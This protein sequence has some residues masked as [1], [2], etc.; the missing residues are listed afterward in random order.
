MPDKIDTPETSCASASTGESPGPGL[1]SRRSRFFAMVGCAALVVLAFP[2]C[3]V[4]WLV[5]V[6]LVPL[7]FAAQGIGGKR[8]F[9]T[10]WITGMMIEGVGFFWISHA[11]LHFSGLPL[12]VAYVLFLGWAAL[13]ALT[14]AVFGWALGRCR[15][16]GAV[17][18]TLPLWVAVEFY[19]PRLFDWHFG[20]ALYQREWLRQAADVFGASGLSYWILLVNALVFLLVEWRRQRAPFPRGTFA[21]VVV[22]SIVVPSYGAWRVENLRGHLQDVPTLRVGMVQPF[23]GQGQKRGGGQMTAPQLFVSHLGQ[24]IALDRASPV[25]LVLWPEGADPYGFYDFSGD[26]PGKNPLDGHRPDM[27][28]QVTI[29][30]KA[31]APLVVG[32]RSED[33]KDQVLNSAAYILPA[34]ESLDGVRV[35]L[36]HKNRL[37]LFGER[38][39]FQSVL[40]QWLI[41]MLPAMTWGAGTSNPTMPLK[42][43][44]TSGDGRYSFRN[45]ICYEAVLPNYVRQTASGA[46]F[47]V[48]LTEDIWYGNSA[49]I[50]Q[51]ASVIR[52]RCVENRTPLLRCTNVGPSGVVDVLG[53][54]A[55]PTAIFAPDA[56]TFAFQPRSFPTVYA[57]WGFLFP[58]MVLILSTPFFVRLIIKNS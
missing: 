51:H 23:T 27:Q 11:I 34:G 4:D 10:G 58:L 30:D 19:A 14:W 16:P 33:A 42:A 6:S 40:P 24:S 25:D 31:T 3:D 26:V 56:K 53:G 57:S 48:N 43:R 18:A 22:L 15:T 54:F 2:N 5:W 35:R 28:S 47:L 52:M 49:H 12:P 39:P 50:A 36:Y 38:L 45:L 13:S 21:V 1:S 44:T 41:Q 9:L 32:C 55:D 37:L 17:L 46:D 20:G 7:F 8:G 29:F